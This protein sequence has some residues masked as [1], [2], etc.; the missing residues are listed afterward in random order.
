MKRFIAL[1]LLATLALSLCACAAPEAPAEPAAPAAEAQPQ[2]AEESPS[3]P[4]EPVADTQLF[5]D[6]L[7]RELTLPAD[8]QKVAATGPMAQIVLFAV[9]PDKLVGIANDWNPGAENYLET[10]YYELPVLGQLY[11]GKGELNLETLLSSGA[12]VVIDVGEAKDG[13]AE[14]LDSL[15]EQ[16]GIPFI[17]IDARTATMGDT[18]R[19]LGR[20][21]N[22][23]S[24]GEALAAYCE[25]VFETVTAI[26][27]QAEEA[28][29]TSLLYCL[30]DEGLNVIA[31]GSY[32]SEILDLLSENLAVVDD[33]SSK[34][35]GNETDLE[36]LLTWDPEVILFPPDSIFD[37]V[38]EDPA[39]QELSAIAGG[40]YYEIPYSIYNWMGFPPSV[41][42]WPGMLWLAELLYPELTD[43]DLYEE[44]CTYY[45]LFYHCDMSR[46]QFNALMENS[47]A[48][49]PQP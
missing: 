20:L 31:A 44:V 46:E 22:M 28:G 8:I 39:W 4:A 32:H 18:F 15:S 16:S 2:S 19:V 25:R 9:C 45:N 47:I 41:Q 3:A 12:Q 30:G 23:E 33:P 35:T 11:G 5:T 1:L 42:R 36:Q 38:S 10:K 14:D 7:G 48:R 17:H 6:S 27:A 34:G 29:K 49:R 21:L 40:R 43:Y 26:A 37:T 13:A 24:E